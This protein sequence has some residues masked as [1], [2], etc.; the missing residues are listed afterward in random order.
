M[1]K[2][3]QAVEMT[4]TELAQ[5]GDSFRDGAVQFKWTGPEHSSAQGNL[6]LWL[7]VNTSRREIPGGNQVVEHVM[8]ATWQPFTLNGEWDDKWANRSLIN[9]I[10]RTGSFAKT[11]YEEFSRFVARK[12]TVR[13][14]IGILSLVGVITDFRPTYVR[15]TKFLW[16]ITF[17][18]HVNETTSE[19]KAGPRPA[20]KQ[21][22]TKWASDTDEMVVR[23]NDLTDGISST[24]LKTERSDAMVDT[25]LEMNDAM[26]R[27]QRISS[28]DLSSDATNKLL[29][30]A[31]TF[32]RMRGAG[33]QIGL[34]L[35]RITS[36]LDIAYDDALWSVR[37]AA[38]L[39]DSITESW[40]LA[41]LSL[42]AEKDMRER[43][44][45][46]PRAIHY[47]KRGESLERIS[48]K[49]Y[50]TP[51]NAMMIF[52]FNRLDSLVFDGTEELI[53]PELSR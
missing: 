42:R 25:L 49:Y 19:S 47:P 28:S 22:I 12:P 45:A 11:M 1:S 40:A 24:A 51:D 16:S 14:Q 15:D 37:H 7:K 33:L 3:P 21:S 41:G 29:L 36:E 38:Y 8:A 32:R 6:E 5:A 23:I 27:I 46:K 18:P 34:A 2:T 35:K 17:S 9:G 13:L 43:A 50:G 44:R 10:V 31:S 53:I 30:M 39:H 48:V 26:D 52:K 20:E 4:I